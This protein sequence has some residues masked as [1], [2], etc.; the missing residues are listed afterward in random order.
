M[1][2]DGKLRDKL[3]CLL[4]E[5]L[6]KGDFDCIWLCAPKI[7]D[8]ESVA[9]FKYSS[10]KKAIQY[11]DTRIE[12]C[13]NEIGRNGIDIALLK[14]RKILAI[15]DDGVPAFEDT[16]YRF[17]YAEV[18]HDELTYVLNAGV[19]Y[20][21]TPDYVKSIQGQYEII[22]SKE[23]DK[24]L[25]EY[26]DESEGHYNVRLASSDSAQ[27]ALLDKHNILLPDAVS[28]VEP[29][30]IYRQGKELIHIKRYGGSSVL[31]HLFSQGLVSGELLKRELQFRK[32][33]NK[34]LPMHLK[35]DDIENRQRPDEYTIVFGI[36]S[37]Q[38]EGLSL[39]FFS[40]I[41]LKHAVN[42]LEAYGHKVKIAKIPVSELK[43]KTKKLP[44]G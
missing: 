33:L 19:W 35:I 39:P 36:I 37:E 24:D 30:D 4:L 28:P 34:R 15:D 16:V 26:N 29:C 44:P 14:R 40:K 6:T 42:R 17:I 9:G 18:W 10:G 20:A 23:Y 43:K 7:V 5:R 13:L 22:K 1:V 12:E 2:K 31:S 11:Y 32:E 25:L 3:D 8:W 38:D 21:I 27:F 41:S